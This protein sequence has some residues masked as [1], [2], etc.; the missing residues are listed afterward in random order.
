LIETDFGKTVGI[1][2]E[3]ISNPPANITWY[4]NARLIEFARHANIEVDASGNRL[5]INNVS[6]E[7]EAIYQCFLDNEAGSASAATL[8]KII[9]FEPKFTRPIQNKTIYSDSNV[10]LSCGEVE[11]SPKPLITWSQLDPYDFE[12]SLL[13][14]QMSAFD[15]ERG[16]QFGFNS[17]PNSY[18]INDGEL[19]INNVN[20]KSQGWYKCEASNLLGTI[21]AKM[22]LQVKSK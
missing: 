20:A 3:G 16:R 4:K 10:V 22:F 6:K 11:G 2:C 9:S 7:D 19:I 12:P 8:V 1:Q 14:N 21:S 18:F 15:N 17:K 5:V 13:K